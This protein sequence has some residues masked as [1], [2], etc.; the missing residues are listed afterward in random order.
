[1]DSWQNSMLNVLLF[2]DP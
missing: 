2:F 1:M